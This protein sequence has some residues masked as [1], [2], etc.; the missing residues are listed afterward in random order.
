MNNKN[1][2]KALEELV[3]EAIAFVDMQYSPDEPRYADKRNQE[4]SNIAELEAVILGGLQAKSGW[5]DISEWHDDIGECFWTRFPVEEPYYA[6]C[7]M[8]DDWPDDWYTHFIPMTVFNHL[9]DKDGMPLEALQASNNGN[10]SGFQP[11]NAGSIPVACSTKA[12][13]VDVEHDIKLALTYIY[14]VAK[15]HEDEMLEEAAD[16]IDG[17]LRTPPTGETD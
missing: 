1:P 4:L 10:S 15:I 6:G 11:E 17:Y 8:C 3:G 13:S 14:G 16:K 9:I 5:R 2:I 12:E 7:P